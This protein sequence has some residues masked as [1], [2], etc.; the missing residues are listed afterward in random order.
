[1]SDLDNIQ[2][3]FELLQIKPGVWE[4]SVKN[5][6]KRPPEEAGDCPSDTEPKY[7][8]VKFE[9]EQAEDD[10]KEEGEIKDDEEEEP[11]RPEEDAPTSPNPV[12]LSIAKTENTDK[13]NEN[14]QVL[15][16]FINDFI[17]RVGNMHLAQTRTVSLRKKCLKL[18]Y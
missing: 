4:S 10:E 7:P 3:L 16:P 2:E 9:E 18:I 17:K 13:E 8:S 14:T 1:M 15:N 11:E 6:E 5:E 12:N